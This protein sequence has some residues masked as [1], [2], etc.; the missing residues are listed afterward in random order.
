M[1]KAKRK[2]FRV[3]RI[4]TRADGTVILDAKGRAIEIRRVDNRFSSAHRLA[5]ITA[6]ERDHTAAV[7]EIFEAP[8]GLAF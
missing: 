6:G 4:T 3:E 7:S 5:V 2:G 8:G 1:S